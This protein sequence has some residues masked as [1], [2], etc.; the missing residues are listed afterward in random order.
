M[1]TMGRVNVNYSPFAGTRTDSI[2]G[3][4]LYDHSQTVHIL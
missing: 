3:N 4:E 1:E 2:V